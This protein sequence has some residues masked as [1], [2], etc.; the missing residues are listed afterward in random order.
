MDVEIRLA[1]AQHLAAL[2]LSP[3]L[4]VAWENDDFNPPATGFLQ[5]QLFRS[6]VQRLTIGPEGHRHFGFLQ[7]TVVLPKNEGAAQADR[8]A[9]IVRDHFPAD[10]WLSSGTTLPGGPTLPVGDTL[11]GGDRILR[12]TQTP[13]IAGGLPDGPWWRVPVTIEF[14]AFS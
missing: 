2:E 1:L 10:L 6:G 5:S 9:E 8:V 11:P 13:V 7:V 4:P 12:V 14:E 3:S